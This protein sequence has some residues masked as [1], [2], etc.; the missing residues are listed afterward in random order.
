MRISGT[1]RSDAVERS[2]RAVDI[3]VPAPILILLLS[4]LEG[5]RQE[6]LHLHSQNTC[7]GGTDGTSGSG[8]DL[9]T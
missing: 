1:P 9:L 3:A 7:L 2:E 4:R 5:L 8:I 6:I